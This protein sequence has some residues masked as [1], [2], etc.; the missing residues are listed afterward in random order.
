MRISILLLFVF[1]AFSVNSQDYFY[2]KYAPFNS[3]IPSP[4]SYL[5]YPIGDQHTRHDQMVAYLE[6]LAEK[7]DRAS[8]TNYGQTYERRK[9]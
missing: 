2:K 9:S 6:M 3:D 8:I 5:G 4:E 7:S 1:G